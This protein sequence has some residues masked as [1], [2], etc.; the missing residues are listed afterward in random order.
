MTRKDLIKF[1]IIN[2]FVIEIK[3][4]FLFLTNL[5]FNEAFISKS[6]FFQEDFESEKIIFRDDY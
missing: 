6:N 5:C 4:Y 2:L 1:C 3:I